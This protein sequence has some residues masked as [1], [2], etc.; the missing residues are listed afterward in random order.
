MLPVHIAKCDIPV[1]LR[2]TKWIDTVGVPFDEAVDLIAEGLSQMPVP[3]R[4]LPARQRFSRRT[5]I[6]GS[7][8]LVALATV[9]G[10]GL[11]RIL[12]STPTHPFTARSVLY[13]L[14]DDSETLYAVNVADGSI[15][16]KFATNGEYR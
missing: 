10:I 14:D 13:T 6:G 4:V 16:W 11:R 15:R 5:L 8:G 12:T 2:G 9:G 7:V 3:S 1:L